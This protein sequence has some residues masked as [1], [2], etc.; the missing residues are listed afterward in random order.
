MINLNG[1]RPVS[2]EG[3]QVLRG[4]ENLYVSC[5]LSAAPGVPV[6]LEPPAACAKLKGLVLTGFPMTDKEAVQ[7]P[8]NLEHLRISDEP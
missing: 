3:I 4:L 2:F 1:V 8:E 7:R 6:S 5:S